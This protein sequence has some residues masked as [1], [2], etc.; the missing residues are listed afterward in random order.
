MF[1]VLVL[2]IFVTEYATI[3]SVGSL[4]IEGIQGR[5]YIP[6][7]LMLGIVFSND[8][9]FIKDSKSIPKRYLFM[10][11]IFVNL[12]ALTYIMFKYL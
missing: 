1:L 5:Y 9:V 10:F 2:A 6:M 3:N 7:L 11:L 12:H 4:Y 8:V